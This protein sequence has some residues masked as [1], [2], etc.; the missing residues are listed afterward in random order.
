M[1][2]LSRKICLVKRLKG[3]LQKKFTEAN[4]FY[5]SLYPGRLL[6][7][8]PLPLPSPCIGAICLCEI[9][10]RRGGIRKIFRCGHGN[11]VLTN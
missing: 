7:I 2:I 5:K 1:H 8:L 11:G 4:F 9:F 3:I 10:R 6:R